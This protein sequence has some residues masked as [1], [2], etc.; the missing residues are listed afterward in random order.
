VGEVDFLLFLVP[1]EER[2]IGD[3]REFKA[4]LIREV[5]VFAHLVAGGTGELHEFFG[6]ARHEEGSIAI[7][8]AELLT[9]G[10][11]ALRADIVGDGAGGSYARI[12]R[13]N[14]IRRCKAR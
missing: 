11:R 6:V 4:V 10:F 5:Q 1:F 12:A 13:R 3:P 9:D 2:E 7:G 8:K 14:I